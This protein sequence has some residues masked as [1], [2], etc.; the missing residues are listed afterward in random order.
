MLAWCV[1]FLASS[2]TANFQGGGYG[3][4]GGYGGGYGHMGGYGGGYGGNYLGGGGNP[5]LA[6][7]MYG[8]PYNKVAGGNLNLGYGGIKSPL[9][10][11]TQ[12]AY[13]NNFKPM[14][15]FGYGG[16][17]G[18]DNYGA[19]EVNKYRYD[20]GLP[21]LDEDDLDQDGLPDHLVATRHKIDDYIAKQWKLGK[22]KL[23]VQVTANKVPLEYQYLSQYH[24]FPNP[25]AG[26]PWAEKSGMSPY[27][28]T[29]NDPKK[30]AY[31]TK[32]VYGGY[33]EQSYGHGSQYGQQPA[34][35]GHGSQ[36]GQQPA[37]YGHGSQYGPDSRQYQSNQNQQH[38][39][40]Q[41]SSEHSN[42][43]KY[44]PPSS[45]KPASRGHK[46]PLKD[47]KKKPSKSKL[48]SVKPSFKP[49][50]TRH[51]PRY[52]QPMQ[53]HSHQPPP[54]NLPQMHQQP[55]PQMHQQQPPQMHQQPPPQMHQQPTYTSVTK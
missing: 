30:E 14:M 18:M 38:G 12:A 35:Y 45:N 26:T 23:T 50:P 7:A 43:S 16:F 29:Y 25:L 17:G 40:P 41:E 28:N 52:D 44:T 6:E 9:N 5:L 47:Y 8:N 46:Q 49:L 1:F 48:K 55:P 27:A 39:Y 15:N 10:V 11:L 36:Y 19:Y 32:N 20:K 53:S 4:A 22:R 3:H 34:Q 51:Q 33:G 42:N 24:G 31:T 2:T 21:M 37:Q 54:Y 13:Q